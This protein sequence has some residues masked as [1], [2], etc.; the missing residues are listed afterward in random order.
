MKCPVCHF[1]K[2]DR[3]RSIEHAMIRGIT[4]S[5]LVESKV[6]PCERHSAMINAMVQGLEL[7]LRLIAACDAKGPA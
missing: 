5:I 6:E 7:A 1:V 4:V 3:E 2:V